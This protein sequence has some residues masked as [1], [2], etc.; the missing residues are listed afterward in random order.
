MRGLSLWGSG[1]V[2]YG[3]NVDMHQLTASISSAFGALRCSAKNG[4]GVL[5]HFEL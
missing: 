5:M 2:N 1:G 4:I 3:N